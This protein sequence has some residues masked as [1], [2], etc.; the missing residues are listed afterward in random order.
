VVIV[1]FLQG[2]ALLQSVMFAVLLFKAL[3]HYNQHVVCIVAAQA[4]PVSQQ[5]FCLHCCCPSCSCI[6]STLFALLLSKALL[7]FVPSDNARS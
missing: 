2:I 7:Y 5:G 3:L 1:F 4:I 6:I